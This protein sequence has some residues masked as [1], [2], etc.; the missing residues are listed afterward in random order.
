MDYSDLLKVPWKEG[1]RD[2]NGLDCWGLCL[3]VCRREGIPLP[4]VDTPQDL[5][6][7]SELILKM[8]TDFE[9]LWNPEPFCLVGIKSKGRFVDHVGVVLEDCQ[10]F[11]H[12]S[13]SRGSV[14]VERLDAP[15]WHRLIAGYYRWK[16]R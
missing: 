13:R 10:R 3:E 8:S 1:G 5:A 4:Q 2:L 9:I 7:L 11:I 16:N 14:A 15:V 6:G 12:C